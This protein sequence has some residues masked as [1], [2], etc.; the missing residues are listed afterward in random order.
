MTSPRSGERINKFLAARIGVSRREADLLVEKGHVTIDGQLAQLA[1]R[2]ELQSEV[3]VKDTLVVHSA[4]LVYI[5]FHKPVGYVCSRRS[6]PGSPTIYELL[7]PEY[8]SLKTVGRLDKDSSGLILL[9]N[10]GDFSHRMTHPSFR[11]TKIYNVTLDA[12]LQPLHRQMVSD[13]GVLLEDGTSQFEVARIEEGNDTLW[14]ITMSE[15][16][17]RQI[18]RTFVALGYTVAAL[19]RTSFGPYSLG[20][21]KPGEYK[22]VTIS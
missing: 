7:P 4:S 6:Q 9:T 3:K 17:N 13:H 18:R 21:I 16:R 15:G 11:K 10:D 5:A 1:D 2:V 8:H 20:D 19:H 12:P 22:L 14:Q